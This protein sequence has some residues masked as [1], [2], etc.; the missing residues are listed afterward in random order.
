MK[1]V[2]MAIMLLL[3]CQSY[4]V[5][6]D[7][8]S[9]G[10]CGDL[11]W[12]IDTN[13]TLTISGIGSMPN[14]VNGADK[15][16][17][18]I[19]YY[20]DINNIIINDGIDYIGNFSFAR[21]INAES[22]RISDTVTNIG[23]RS[24]LTCRTITDIVLPPHLDTLSHGAFMGCTSLQ[25][26]HLYNNITSIADYAFNNCDSLK[27]VYFYGTPE[28]WNAIDINP[29][30]NEA[31]LNANIVYISEV[32]PTSISISTKPTYIIGEDT[33]LDIAVTLNHNDGTATTLSPDEYTLET[34][35]DPNV[36]GEYNVKVTYGEFSDEVKVKVEPLK[37]VSLSTSLGT[38]CVPMQFIE[39]TEL[40]LSDITI[41][42][43]YNNG[44]T[45]EI[46][47]YTVSGYDNSKIG[48][49]TLTISYNDLSTVISVEVVR[50]S[51]SGI[52]IVTLPDK[53]YYCNDETELDLTG[54]TVKSCFN[55]DTTAS[56]FSYKVTGFNGT[57]A[58]K[59]TITV[60]CE[61]FSDTFEVEVKRYDFKID[62]NI[63]KRYDFDTKILTVG[64]HIASRTDAK[65]VKV[66]VAV[67]DN[68]NALMGVKAE[69]VFFDTN[70]TKDLNID[71]ENVEYPF[72]CI[73]VFV[74]DFDLGKMLPLAVGI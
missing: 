36:E 24:F 68:N 73:K 57:K 51:L 3:I 21:C 54:L 29:E 30:G 70:E 74:W 37:M 6:A 33:A 15:N 12:Q 32:L 63:S 45:E 22:I 72:S 25:S 41:T 44:N 55:N 67:Y 66:L 4:I 34:D 14:Y 23:D 26:L 13:Y 7:N 18:W 17:P 50:K 62:A 43:V 35:F 53:L 52:Q 38:S 2:I 20:A 56:C 48:V 31:L 65:A 39:G 61:G 11:N 27:I 28:E 59:Q 19:D 16:I 10:K 71:V 8:I 9:F 49:Q 40:D 69:N 1:K 64:A 46:T 42:G 5:Y 47:D 58:G 60:S